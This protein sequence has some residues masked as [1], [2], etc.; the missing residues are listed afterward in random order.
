[1][2]A[3]EGGREGWVDRSAGGLEEVRG[4]SRGLRAA[5]PRDLMR[6]SDPHPQDHRSGGSCSQ[7][8]PLGGLWRISQDPLRAVA[9]NSAWWL[10]SLCSW[11]HEGT[12]GGTQTWGAV[13][14]AWASPTPPGTR[15]A[16][17]AVCPAPSHA[18]SRAGPRPISA[19][20]AAGSPHTHVSPLNWGPGSPHT[21]F[22]GAARSGASGGGGPAAARSHAAPAPHPEL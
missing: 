11:T 3:L 12:L 22:L 16:N 5:C 7:G 6:N 1:M 13:G 9:S 8:S 21:T 4:P 20:G 14:A 15:E 17:S 2:K 18:L 19:Q 10:L